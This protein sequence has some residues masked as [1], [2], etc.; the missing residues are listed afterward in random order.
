[1]KVK[2][3]CPH[4]HLGIEVDMTVD[5]ELY[6]KELP[7]ATRTNNHIAKRAVRAFALHRLPIGKLTMAQIM[8]DYNK[9][10]IANSAPLLTSQQL[11]TNLSSLDLVRWR[12]GRSRGFHVPQEWKDDASAMSERVR[13]AMLSEQTTPGGSHGG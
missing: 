4:C 5:K 6:R 13:S 10:A 8:D 7:G 3:E 2:I 1:M 11:S 9:W 12:D